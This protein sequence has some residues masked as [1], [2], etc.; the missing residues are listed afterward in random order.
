MPYVPKNK[1]KPR[2][3]RTTNR[4]STNKTFKKRVKAI[5]SSLAEDKQAYLSLDESALVTFNS[6]INNTAEM[7]QIVPNIIDGAG[8]NQRIGDKI[9]PTSLKIQGYIRFVPNVTGNTSGSASGVCQVGV[10]LFIVSLKT[11]SNYTEVISSATPLNSLLRK[12][13]TNTAFTGVIS[14]LFA[15][16]NNDL[17]TLHHSKVFYLT[18]SF[19]NFGTNVG[20]WETDIKNQI[21][22]F[23]YN[24]KVKSKTFKYDDGT[25]SSLLPTNYAPIML[26]GYTYLNAQTPDV[27]AAN[28]GLFYNSILTYEDM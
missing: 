26:L 9:K 18:Q 27:I 3:P 12:G 20:Y 19:N 22:F 14:D 24:L 21:K 7:L 10:R 13:G 6:A 25:S 28:C 1:R 16:I 2:K 17:W 4:K 15:P 5:I 23:K 11:K 8:E